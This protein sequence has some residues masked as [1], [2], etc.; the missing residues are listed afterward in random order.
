[1]RV[2]ISLLC[3]SLVL[4]ACNSTSKPAEEELSDGWQPLFDGKTLGKWEKTQFGGEGEITI[5]DKA[6]TMGF[7]SPMT[8]IT[9]QG[10]PPYRINYEIEL[11][12][13]RVDGTDF[14][15][16]LKFPVKDK[17]CSLICG[18]WGG[19]VVGLSNIN[20]FDAS[21]NESTQVVAF[22]NKKWYTIRLRVEEGRIRAWIDEEKLIDV[23][24]G[25]KDID[26][27]PE[28]ELNKPLGFSCFDTVAALR[29]IHI[30][31]VEPEPL[32]EPDPFLGF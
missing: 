16:G 31:Q 27:R 19:T 15:C 14:F 10:K 1:M 17:P 11:E 22:E 4:T 21:E 8:G 28:V 30:R 24:T 3:L 2:L 5:K 23:L 18:G 6:I 12:A 32:P 20:F 29:Y 9:W 26:I 25:G 13:M 7:G